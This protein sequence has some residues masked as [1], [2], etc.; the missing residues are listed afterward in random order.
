[1]D[2]FL[3]GAISCKY[4]KKG[5]RCCPVPIKNELMHR[6]IIILSILF[7]SISAR[8]QINDMGTG[9]A[10]TMTVQFMQSGNDSIPKL[11]PFLLPLDTF[12]PANR[13]MG[14]PPWSYAPLSRPTVFILPTFGFNGSVGF[15]MYSI[16]HP[17]KFFST[18]EGFNG[19][20][21]PQ[22][23]IAQ[24]MMLGNTLRLA[25]NFYMMSGILY[26]AQLGVKFN[27]WGIGERSGFIYN[28]RPD[29]SIVIW[30]QYYRAVNVY[31]PVFFPGARSGAAINLPATPEV[32]SVGVQANFT[33]G[34]FIIGVGTSVTPPKKEP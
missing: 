31:M 3:S 17:E 21:I 7:V 6:Y 13:L 34:E 25:R 11:I 20:N 12:I 1:M 28:P 22:L 10:D 19:F 8:A 4:S 24:Q 5:H 15:G 26:G 33:V 2:A 29:I 32:F 9:A 16:Q 23:Y 30:D 14:Y 27:L 18:L